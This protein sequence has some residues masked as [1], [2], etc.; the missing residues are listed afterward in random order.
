MKKGSA[1][2][3]LIGLFGFSTSSFA[4]SESE[5]EDLADLTAVFVYLKNDCGYKALP[6][7]RIQKALRFFALQ[8]RWDLSNYNRYNMENLGKESYQDLSGIAIANHKKCRF[9]AQSSLGLLAYVK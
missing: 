8:N 7:N 2:L 1:I 5:A 6:D 3:L 9:L 4:L